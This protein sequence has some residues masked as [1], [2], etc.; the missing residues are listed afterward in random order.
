MA[1]STKRV[2]RLWDTYV[3]S[4][5]R[6]TATVRGVFGDPKARIVSLV[7]RSKKLHAA[8]AAEYGEAGTIEECGGFGIC[9]VATRGYIWSSRLVGY[10]VQAAAK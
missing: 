4:G 3:F 5:F 8:G 6:P 7:R 10:F 1:T 2:R 9:P